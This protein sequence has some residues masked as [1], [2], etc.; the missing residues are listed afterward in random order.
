MARAA[1]IASIKDSAHVNYAPQKWERLKEIVRARSFSEG[2]STQLA[3]GRPSNFYFN[4]KRTMSQPEALSLIAD[5]V[6]EALCSDEC[7]YVG[8]LEMGAV[9]IL[10]AVAIRSFEN[11]NPIPLIWVRKRRKEH[12]TRD[13][14]EGEPLEALDGKRVVMVDDVTTTGGSVLQ[15]IEDAQKAGMHVDT[16]IT[17]VDRQEGA[18]QNLQNAGITL[19]AIYN[20]DDFRR[21]A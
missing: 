21:N 3:S 4:M 13:L 1:R 10:N 15:A 5:L 11:G 18:V 14:I 17:L 8:G 7:D 9:P 19:V 6:L 20:A 16:V 12:G 2:Q